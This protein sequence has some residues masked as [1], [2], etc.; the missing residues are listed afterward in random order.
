MT[1]KLPTAIAGY[2]AADRDRDAAAISWHFTDNAVVKDD[3]KLHTGREA[4]RMWMSHSWK[5]YSATTE[6]F[7]IEDQGLATV[8]TSHVAG[9]FPGSPVDLRYHFVLEG[10]L[11][12]KL[13]VT[14]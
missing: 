14:Q 9:D 1:M 8:V 3:G 7:A 6:P 2:F 11:I 4:I 10:D 12:A 13:E 5:K